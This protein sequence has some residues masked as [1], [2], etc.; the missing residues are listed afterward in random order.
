MVPEF[1]EDDHPRASDGKFGASGGSPSKKSEL[2][3]KARAAGEGAGKTFAEALL[4][5]AGRFDEGMKGGGEAAEAAAEELISGNPLDPMSALEAGRAAFA[6][7]GTDA[8]GHKR[9]DARTAGRL[10]GMQFGNEGNEEER[11]E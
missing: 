5:G 10:A 7:A 3:A 11:E 4:K 8:D 2:H 9:V 1:E 6:N